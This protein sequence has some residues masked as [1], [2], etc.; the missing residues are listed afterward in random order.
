M[1]YNLFLE[2]FKE[3]LI[4]KPYYSNMIKK[5]IGKLG[6]LVAKKFLISQNYIFLESNYRWTGGEIDLILKENEEI[7]FVEVKTRTS[8]ELI[9]ANETVSYK[10]IEKIKKTINVYSQKNKSINRL[11]WRIDLITVKLNMKILKTEIFH[12]KNI[13]DD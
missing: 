5:I 6:E 2:I 4:F 10:Q 1:T 3:N 11:A 7:V 8:L 13:T 9:S 12:F